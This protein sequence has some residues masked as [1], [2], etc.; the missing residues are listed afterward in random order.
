M[1]DLHEAFEAWLVRGARDEL[2][3]GMAVHASGCPDCLRAAGALDALA[4]ID[5]G[6]ADMPPMRIHTGREPRRRALLPVMATAAVVVLAIGTGVVAGRA[7]LGSA[8]TDDAAAA[9][10][11]VRE[12][13]LG[14]QGG[15][16]WSAGASPSPTAGASPTPTATPSPSSSVGTGPSGPDP[17]TGVDPPPVTA[18]PSTPRPTPTPRATTPAPTPTPTD[19]AT[20]IPTIA[21][22]PEPTAV[23]QCSD[24]IDNDDDGHIDFG[25]DPGCLSP[26]DD[27][28]SDA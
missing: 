28:E 14:G 11:T 24:G 4:A 12:G 13:V 18:P 20:P 25:A 15:S 7:L 3:R 1:S 21:P 27:D 26:F 17:T 19:Q 22:T 6:A 8:A 23:P 2:P 9:S 10:P 16:V 5:P